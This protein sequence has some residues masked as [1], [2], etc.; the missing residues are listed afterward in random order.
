MPKLGREHYGLIISG[1][2]TNQEKGL[3]TLNP[4]F[5]NA[6]FQTKNLAAWANVGAVPMMQQALKCCS[7]CAEV[8]HDDSCVLVEQCDPF[9][10][11]YYKCVT[12]LDDEQHNKMVCTNLNSMG[13]NVDSFVVK[14]LCKA[15][16]LVQHP[17]Q[18]S[19]EEHIIALANLGV[20]CWNGDSIL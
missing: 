2:D 17:K 14:A 7:V 10:V 4:E 12:M 11:F 20:Y 13:Y 19:E 18:T 1:R 6:F 15:N 3:S 5:H 8:L 9:K 16:N